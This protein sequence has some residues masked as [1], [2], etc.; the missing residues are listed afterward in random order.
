LTLKDHYPKLK[1]S[2]FTIPFDYETEMSDMLRTTKED[3]LRKI[4]ENKDWLEFIPHGLTHFDREFEKADREI[5]ETYV[6]NVIPEMVK[7]GLPEDRIVKGFCAPQW[8]WNEEV[9]KVLDENGWWGAIDRNQPF[10]PRTKKVYV[11]SH[12]IDEPFWL[13]N[14]KFIKLHGHISPPSRNDLEGSLLKLLKIPV[15][16]DWR[17][18]SEAVE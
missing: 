5:M 8:L 14:Q 15:D 17:F 12:S 10:M 7:S 11:Y 1:V 4:N 3:A 2:L 6:Q 16:A 13:S 9:I 18:V